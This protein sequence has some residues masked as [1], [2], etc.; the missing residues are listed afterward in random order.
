MKD[1]EFIK[2]FNGFQ[3]SISQ[4]IIS[5]SSSF[6][7]PSHNPVPLIAVV[8]CL[9]ER[10][11]KSEKKMRKWEIGK[12]YWWMRY[13]RYELKSWFSKSHSLFLKQNL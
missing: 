5:H 6:E 7:N 9:K 13:G 4:L 11:G 1:L 12:R 8:S 3:I 2:F 10:D